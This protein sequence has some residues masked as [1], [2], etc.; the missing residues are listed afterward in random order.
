[1]A[2]ARRNEGGEGGGRGEGSYHLKAK[3]ANKVEWLATEHQEPSAVARE[4]F[5]KRGEFL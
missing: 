4:R 5:T 2:K 3:Y 1:M